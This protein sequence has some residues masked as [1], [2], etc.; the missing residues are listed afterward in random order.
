MIAVLHII[1][2]LLFLLIKVDSKYGQI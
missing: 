1:F 2:K